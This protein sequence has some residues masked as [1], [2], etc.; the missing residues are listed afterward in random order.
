MPSNV[1]SIPLKASPLASSSFSKA[2]RAHIAESFTDTHPD[3]FT[4][5]YKEVARLRDRVAHMDVHTANVEAALRYHA[6]LVFMGT[7]FP[8]DINISFPW[9]VSFPNTLPLFSAGLNLVESD[10]PPASPST[11]NTPHRAKSYM[12]ISGSSYTVAHPDL[13]Y[14]RSAVL[15]S[16]AA[17]YSSL[18]TGESRKDGESIKKAIAAFQTSAGILHYILTEMVPLISHLSS[19]MNARNVDPDV[20]PAMLGC[21]REAMLAQA[22]EC[23]WQKAVVD[24]LKDATIAKLA[25]RV[26]ELY[27][28]AIGLA[29][30]GA[31]D[32]AIKEGD[33]GCELPREWLNHMSIKKWHFAAASQFR[34]S[35]EDLGA[36]RYGD[37][38]GRLKLAEGLVKK[39]LDS[40]KRGTSE[41]LQA[42]LKSLQ[43]VISTNL[44]RAMKDNDLIYLEPVTPASNLTPIT[45]ASMVDAK[46]PIEVSNPIPYLRDTPAP[47]YGKPLFRE[48][49]PYG[50]HVAISI[51]EERKESFIREELEM[52][53]E[54]LDNLAASALQSLNLPGSLQALEQPVGLPP[55]L[56]RKS[57]EVQS[58]GGLRRLE[59]LVDDVG[60]V[61]RVD[62]D[63]WREIASILRQEETEDANAR[64]LLNEQNVRR[65][66]SQG[67]TYR[68]KLDEFEQTMLHARASDQLVRTKLSE[69]SQ[70]IEVLGSGHDALLAYVPV[71]GRANQLNQAE[72]GAVRALRVELEGLEDLRDSRATISEEAKVMSKRHDIRPTIM[73][74][75]GMIASRSNAP[76]I[77]EAAHF[78]PLLEQEMQGY[79]T[80]R[81]EMEYS[82]KE[83]EERLEIIRQKNDDFIEARKG[84]KIAKKREEALQM[85]DLSYSKYRE[86]S[87][88]LVEGL[89]FYNSLAKL[90]SD[91]RDNVKQW[92]RSRQMD[93]AELN[94]RAKQQ[95]MNTAATLSPVRPKASVAGAATTSSST[96]KRTT[97]S[98]AREAAEAD[99]DMQMPPKWGAWQGGDIRFND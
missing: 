14:E 90:M 87:A 45:A 22:Q 37:E 59:T 71:Q 31:L 81:K 30:K 8:A 51:F 4:D 27:G 19:G 12:K 85:M 68:L 53:R 46:V 62:E 75:A 56:L 66:D 60:R 7:K 25:A 78:E 50:V 77:I 28:N 20:Q 40:P 6:Q 13:N 72:N 82:E 29:T 54:E 49:V 80:L 93:I 18:G 11:S 74:E 89:K 88:N 76:L 38:I 34:K 86:L 84:D 67:S 83:Q 99:K 3:A 65:D 33:G 96:P 58:E 48:L 52:K 43:A 73:R 39:A 64:Q 21:L 15:F 44:S 63:I 69:W 95:S 57:E 42:D 17:L 70:P 10:S 47:A 61:S 55:S 24:R 35:C 98:Q 26:S 32:D 41:A 2:L 16:L 1:L 92:H 91:F 9:S 97:R 36:N 5:D 23:F 79:E 94:N